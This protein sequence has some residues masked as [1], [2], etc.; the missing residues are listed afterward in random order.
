VEDELKGTAAH[1]HTHTHTHTED[2]DDDRVSGLFP[3]LFY[4]K[5]TV[6]VPAGAGAD[7]KLAAAA[8]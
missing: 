7:G 2:D 4:L 8:M 3:V 6:V 5:V 1:T